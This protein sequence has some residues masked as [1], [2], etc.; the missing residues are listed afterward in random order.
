[1]THHPDE[2]DPIS[3]LELD[4]LANSGDLD[5]ATKAGEVAQWAYVQSVE[6]LCALLC[7]PPE[8]A[9]QMVNEWFLK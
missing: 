5:L 2:I 3:Q 6:A 1:M 7:L 8:V 9:E 4:I